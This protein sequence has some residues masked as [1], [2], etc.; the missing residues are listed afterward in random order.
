MN[1]DNELFLG[2]K[3]KMTPKAWLNFI[4]NFNEQYPNYEQWDDRFYI[5]LIYDRLSK[6]HKVQ[7]MYHFGRPD[8]KLVFKNEKQK[9]MFLMRWS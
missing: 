2:N 7:W 9:N 1:K 4:K 3:E 8:A 5:G 6:S